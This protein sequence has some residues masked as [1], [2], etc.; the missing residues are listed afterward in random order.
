M[1]ALFKKP[2]A[3]LPWFTRLEDGGAGLNGSLQ[4]VSSQRL[5]VVFTPGLVL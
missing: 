3:N 1:N 5:E 2:L 4:V